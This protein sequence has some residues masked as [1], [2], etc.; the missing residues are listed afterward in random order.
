MIEVGKEIIVP[1][2]T[3]PIPKKITLQSPIRVLRY[4]QSLISTKPSI[5]TQITTIT[6]Y[7]NWIIWL[8]A[9][10]NFTLGTYLSLN[11]DGTVTRVTLHEDGS[12]TEFN[13]T[14]ES[15]A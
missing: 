14:D 3:R 6:S 13:L 15:N 10:G 4:E 7:R 11:H 9:N 2:P 8:T 12:V 1:L 5:E